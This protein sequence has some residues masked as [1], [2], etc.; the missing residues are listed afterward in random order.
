MRS[1]KLDPAYSVTKSYALRSYLLPYSTVE[2]LIDSRGVED[3]VDRLRATPYGSHLA[4]IQRPYTPLK[5]ERAFWRN[6]VDTHFSLM[7][8]SANQPILET[9][10]RRHIHVNLKTVLR[11]K[12]LGKTY[13]E[14]MEAVDPYPETL[15]RVRDQLMRAVNAKD[16]QTAVAE[17]SKTELG[18]AA[19]IALRVW[20]RRKDL[21]A[22]DTV[23]D[24]IFLDS[25]RQAYGRLPRA[26]R[27][28]YRKLVSLD[29]DM[30]MVITILRLKSW[31]LPSAEIR[32]FIPQDGIELK[33]EVVERLI[34][35]KEAGEAV[36]ILTEIF[37]GLRQPEARD[38]PSLIK[39]LENMIVAEKT[40]IASKY[41]YWK[42]MKNV[43]TLA[44]LVLKEVE[45]RNLSTIAT[46]LYESQIPGNI[47]AR[48]VR[49]I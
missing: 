38:F 14:I 42:P 15:L 45:V 29:L 47:T 3:F 22:F 5:V 18:A 19:E 34:G 35:C 36:D 44:I 12:A 24:R 17:V 41:Y 32:E 2:E 4:Q 40:S 25:L 21:A 43:L 26:D 37:T 30:G 46:G 10:F 6:L 16:L 31:E 20:S 23:L 1:I 27:L 39:G 28:D 48:L 33:G 13:E 7:R 9:Y 11:G 49:T 8:T